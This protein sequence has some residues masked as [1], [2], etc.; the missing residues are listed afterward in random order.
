MR[1]VYALCG[2]LGLALICQSSISNAQTN[3][4]K[5]TTLE[6][7]PQ[8]KALQQQTPLHDQQQNINYQFGELSR[9]ADHYKTDKGNVLH[10]YTDV[11]EYFFLP[12]KN[13]AKKIFEIGVAEGASLKMLRDYFPHAVIY[14][15]DIKDTSHLNSDRLKTFLADQSDRKQLQKFID[16]YGSDFD[17][18]IDDGGHTMQQQQ[19]S[20]GFLFKHAKKGGYYILEDVHTS[21]YDIYRDSFN[22][23]ENEGNTSLTMINKFIRSGLITSQYMTE[24]EQKYLMDNIEYCSLYSRAK[25][26]SITC[27]F[28]KKD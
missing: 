22:A 8:Q 4:K 13:E 11:Y 20:L 3:P 5:D 6:H 1:W 23:Q 28:K 7:I 27:I 19:V 14:G 15:I 17:I 25:G 9:L 2:F 21:I 16:A 12:K 24:N 26:H 18:I 10:K